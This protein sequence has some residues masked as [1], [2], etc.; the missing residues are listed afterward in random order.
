MKA[1]FLFFI[2]SYSGLSQL[3]PTAFNQNNKWFFG[4]EIGSNRILSND[5][6]KTNDFQFGLL[7]EYFVFESWSLQSKIKYYKTQVAFSDNP[8]LLSNGTK[9]YQTL[10]FSGEII[11][12]PITTNF[13][14]A[15]NQKFSSFL[16]IGFGLNAEIKSAYDIPNRETPDLSDFPT[17][18]ISFNG[19]GG[20]QYALSSKTFIFTSLEL[21]NGGYK[22]T[23]DGF[24][25]TR[26]RT[27]VNGLLNFGIKHN[28]KRLFRK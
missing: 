1:I 12:I 14:F 20:L 3:Q 11:S 17:K 8:T 7:A 25:I 28:L 2:I 18:Y 26:N 13:H 9:P 22:G 23:K 4:A 21:N 6:I 19:G 16:S 15:F 5:F 27:S 24:L 10:F